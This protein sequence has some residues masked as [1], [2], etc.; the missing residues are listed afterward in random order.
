M[1]YIDLSGNERI[2][3]THGDLTDKRLRNV[4]ERGNTF[5][6]AESYFAEL[7]KLKP[8]DIYVSDV[9]GAYVPTQLIGP[10]LPAALDKAGKPFAPESPPMPARKTR[11]ASASA[12]SFAGPCRSSR[13]ARLP[14]T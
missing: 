14:A 11:S 7:K 6:K 13:A 4:A 2:K 12:A 10:Y 3:V 9:I 5:V 1:T 8:G